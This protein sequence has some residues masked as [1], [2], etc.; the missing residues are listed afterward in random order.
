MEN[1]NIENTFARKHSLG[2]YSKVFF[3][4]AGY[5][6]RSNETPMSIQIF[7]GLVYVVLSP[8][9]LSFPKY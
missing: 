4:V 6:K 8:K 5:L 3:S 9:I 1:E 7:T 2:K